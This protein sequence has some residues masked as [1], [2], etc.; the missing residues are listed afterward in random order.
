M[1]VIDTPI[2][3]LKLVKLDVHRDDRGHFIE[4]HHNIKYPLA[5]LDEPF[6]QDNLAFSHRNVL[7]GLHYQ[8]PDWQGKLVSVA[9]GEIFDVAVDI[10]PDSPTFG[11]WYGVALSAADG[12]QL[13][14]APG[15]AHGYC[16]TS[17]TAV[18]IYKCTEIYRPE[19]E[20]VLLWND[21]AVNV[22]WPIGAPILSA[23][24]AQ[25]HSFAALEVVAS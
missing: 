3:G 22:A 18:V 21:P 24:D 20:R 19:Q 15:F 11:R 13:Y 4:T 14:V 2:A 7:R 23:K 17:E 9:H 10:R 25:G 12:L 6:V 16:V 8:Y 5:G 1:Q